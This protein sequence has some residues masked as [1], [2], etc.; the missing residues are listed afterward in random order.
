V[1]IVAAQAQVLSVFKRVVGKKVGVMM[2]LCSILLVLVKSNR[3][4]NDDLHRR[5]IYFAEVDE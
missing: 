5:T 1:K 4:P 2:A 3:E